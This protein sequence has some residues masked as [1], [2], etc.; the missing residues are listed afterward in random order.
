VNEWTEATNLGPYS[1]SSCPY[2]RTSW[3]RN[4]P[5]FACSAF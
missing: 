3:K 1:S 5:K 4:S 2:S